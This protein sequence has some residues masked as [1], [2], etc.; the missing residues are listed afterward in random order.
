M[1]PVVEGSLHDPSLGRV[2]VWARIL[3]GFT[4]MTVQV[5]FKC[6]KLGLG[7]GYLLFDVETGVVDGQ[8]WLP[9]LLVQDIFSSFFVI[10]ETLMMPKIR[11]LKLQKIA[12]R[13]NMLAAVAASGS[14]ESAAV[15]HVVGFETSDHRIE[16]TVVSWRVVLQVEKK[17][18][19]Q[20]LQCTSFSLVIRNPPPCKLGSRLQTRWPFRGTRSLTSWSLVPFLIKKLDAH[21]ESEDLA[22]FQPSSKNGFELHKGW[23]VG[24][25]Q[26][27]C[28]SERIGGLPRRDRLAVRVIRIEKILTSPSDTWLT[29]SGHV[30]CPDE[31]E[32][33]PI[34]ISFSLFYDFCC[35]FH[36]CRLQIM[37]CYIWSNLF[38]LTPDVICYRIP[39]GLLQCQC[40]Q[41]IRGFSHSLPD[42]LANI[43]PR[44]EPHLSVSR[45]LC[46][47]TSTVLSIMVS[48]SVAK[49]VWDND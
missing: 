11:L 20:Q 18:Q 48:I 3:H 23:S 31:P 15:C 25:W 9:K 22:P 10:G 5:S 21:W 16:G 41:L 49:K 6:R 46:L 45:S 43:V 7:G 33:S 27:R 2:Y 19:L 35:F 39:W 47:S 29:I 38:F 4:G 34:F 14:P 13:C 12:L 8:D 40:C 28:Y 32:P 1:A 36:S 42:A 30:G 17:L 44:R 26:V 24:F 37:K